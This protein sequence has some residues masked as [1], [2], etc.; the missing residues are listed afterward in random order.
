MHNYNKVYDNKKAEQTVM[1]EDIAGV[2]EVVDTEEVIET[3]EVEAAPAPVEPKTGVVA[4]C[5]R[6]KV[7]E[8]PS[9]INDLNVICKIEEGTKLLVS[10]EETYAEWYKV[11]LENG[12]EGYCMKKFINLVS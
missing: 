4:N 11:T 9:T 6:L 8:K 7:R 1:A 2:E 3:V 5:E 12:V 10:E